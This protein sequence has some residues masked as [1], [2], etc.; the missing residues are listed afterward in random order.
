MRVLLADVSSSPRFVSFVS[1][2]CVQCVAWSLGM[3]SRRAFL[4]RSELFGHESTVG[5]RRVACRGTDVLKRGRIRWS[6][7]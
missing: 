7:K 4:G 3:G 5:R 2:F 1:P 6:V